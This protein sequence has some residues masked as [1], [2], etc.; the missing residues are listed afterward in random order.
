[1]AF[2]Y[3]AQQGAK[4]VPAGGWAVAAGIAA[5][6]T[7]AI[8]QVAVEYFESGKRL[9]RQQMRETYKNILKRD[10]ATFE[11]ET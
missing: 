7:W 10:K 8:G 1:M 5:L 4:L 3:L 2:R 9:T 6:G 11:R